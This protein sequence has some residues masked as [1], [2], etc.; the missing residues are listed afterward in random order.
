MTNQGAPG[1]GRVILAL[2]D[3][4][5][6]SDPVRMESGG[7]VEANGQVA[8]PYEEIVA[9]SVTPEYLGPGRRWVRGE[10]KTREVKIAYPEMQMTSFETEKGAF[11]AAGT[12]IPGSRIEA[13]A[14]TRNQGVIG[15][16]S[17][18]ISGADQV[19]RLPLTLVP[20]GQALNVLYVGEMPAKE[21][22]QLVASASWLGMDRVS[23]NSAPMTKTIRAANA[24]F[25]FD[26]RITIY[27]GTEPISIQGFMTA[28]DVRFEGRA[29]GAPPSPVGGPYA[30][31][32]APNSVLT[33]RFVSMNIFT[34][35][36]DVSL[37]TVRRESLVSRRTRTHLAGPLAAVPNA[38][39]S[40]LARITA[41]RASVSRVR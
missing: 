4:I 39:F 7:L 3:Q 15:L 22:V 17:L 16:A 29:V 1:T 10:S 24:L 18:E 27:S 9:V 12:A 14:A 41:R 20:A 33:F 2:G 5:L 34:F 28:R 30:L 25:E 40:G 32:I 23:L 36:S 6:E 21:E 19:A 31:T 11:G 38:L 8:V 13:R 35:Q 37:A 26:D